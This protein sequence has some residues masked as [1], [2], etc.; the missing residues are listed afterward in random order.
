MRNVGDVKATASGG[1]LTPISDLA[2]GK[3]S[4]LEAFDSI[5]LERLEERELGRCGDRATE[6][7]L[8]GDRGDPIR[9]S[10]HG[11]KG[12]VMMRVTLP[13]GK[14][15]K[16]GKCFGKKRKK[17]CIFPV[18]FPENGKKKRDNSK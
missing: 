4:D 1:S 12:H 2:V 17:T 16:G 14:G 10:V 15:Y 13:P 8:A 3:N 9:E 11:L 6:P 18:L 5:P 7:C